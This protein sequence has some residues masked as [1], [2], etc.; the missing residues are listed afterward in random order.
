MITTTSGPLE[1]RYFDRMDA[2][3]GDKQRLIKWLPERARAVADMGAG[4]GAL[5]ASIVRRTGASVYAL[6]SNPDAVSRMRDDVR[7]ISDHVTVIRGD[8]ESLRVM[9]T[10]APFD[11]VV[12]SSVLHEVYS[13]GASDDIRRYAAWSAAIDSAVRSVRSGGRFII[14]DG[15]AP[16]DPLRRARITPLTSEDATLL[17]RYLDALPKVSSRRLRRVGDGYEHT[18]RAVAEALFTL[19]WLD[20]DASPEQFARETSETYQ[21]A[22]LDRYARRVMNISDA[23]GAPLRLVHSEEYIQPEYVEH[24]KPRF[25][26]SLASLESDPRHSELEP[27]LPSTNAIWVFERE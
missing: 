18:A 13:Y 14:R 20:A 7:G 4:S 16:R 22:D 25:Q 27:W 26:T 23:A 12:C 19:N 11:A 15:V 6:D 17:E 2:A 8:F 10:A 3:L 9:G 5:A 1:A 24:L 21:L